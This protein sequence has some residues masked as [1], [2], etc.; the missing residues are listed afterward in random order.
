[1]SK[2]QISTVQTAPLF[3]FT[4]GRNVHTKDLKLA[5]DYRCFV[6]VNYGIF[7]LRSNI[8]ELNLKRILKFISR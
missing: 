1:M 3:N 4:V 7:R 8:T 5:L 6:F 2:N